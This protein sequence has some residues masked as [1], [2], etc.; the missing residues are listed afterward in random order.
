MTSDESSYGSVWA[1]E[2][3][4]LFGDRDDLN[5][6]GECLAELAGQGP[7]LEL[8]IGTGR[9]ALPLVERGVHVTGIEISPEMVTRLR[10]KPRGDR[11]RVV[12]GSIT[13]T[14]VEGAFTL[15]YCTFSTLFLLRDQAAQV[16]TL[17]N[18]AAHLA[19]KG[20]VLIEAFVPDPKR[21]DRH[22]M[23]SVSALSP[24]G[25]ELVAA[26]HDP[27]CQ[28]IQTQHLI[29]E[30]G[31]VRLRPNRLRYAW[32][33]EIDLMAQLAGLRLVQRWGAWDKSPFTR[34]SA[35]HVSIYE[36]IG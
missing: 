6:L 17:S 4:L 32:P 34:D 19:P 36:R 28:A 9:T 22:Q 20:R 35:M 31:T 25:I 16:A 10:A 23:V 11:I 14:R 8:G 24:D 30:G 12:V 5:Q 33:S 3:D 13:D 2:Y 7:A 26:T 29:V 27:A 18:A 1:S 15:V 21:W